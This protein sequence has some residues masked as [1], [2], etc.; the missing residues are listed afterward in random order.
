MYLPLLPE[1]GEGAGDAALVLRHSGGR[2]RRG[3]D[4]D[5][6]RGAPERD[7]TSRRGAPPRPRGGERRR[8]RGGGLE[9]EGH[10]GFLSCGWVVEAGADW[11]RGVA[12]HVS[13]RGVFDA[14]RG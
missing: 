7:P 2:R 6:G 11:V 10:G 4:G 3:P 13:D 1:L 8:P 12:P 14:V 9:R 5:H